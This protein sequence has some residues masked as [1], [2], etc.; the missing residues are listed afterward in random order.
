MCTGVACS[1]RLCSL[2]VV[3]TYCVVPV[4]GMV[5]CVLRTVCG[6]GG[7]LCSV[8]CVLGVCQGLC[9]TGEEHDCLMLA[10][11]SLGGDFTLPAKMSAV[12]ALCHHI[13]KTEGEGAAEQHLF[14][15]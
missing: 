5:L 7:E 15:L 9:V 11:S 13:L 14:P 6:C 4:G 3:L 10:W 1:L 2:S 8:V 12:A